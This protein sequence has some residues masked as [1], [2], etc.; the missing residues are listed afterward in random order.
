MKCFSSFPKPTETFL[1]TEAV[2]NRIFDVL[3]GFEK[4]DPA[5]VT[6]VAH[7]TNDLGLDSLDAVEVVMAL[8]EEF[9]VEIPDSEAERILTVQDAI[10]F[11]TAHPRA[12]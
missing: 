9:T 7:F 2:T 4:V 12:Q 5:K 1:E 10:Y 6:E 8:E 11:I 3:T